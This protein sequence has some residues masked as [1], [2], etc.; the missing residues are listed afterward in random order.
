MSKSLNV[1]YI[2]PQP[3]PI[4]GATSKRRR[5]M[6]DYMNAHGIKSHYLI[7][8]FKQRDKRLNGIQGQYG[9]CEYW[10]ITP[11]AE[12]RMFLKF[13]KKGK[14]ILKKWYVKGK[15]NIVV[16]DTL[17]CWYDYPFYSKARRL[18]YKIVFDQVETS[19]L[20][21]EEVGVLRKWNLL[22]SEW[23]SNKAFSLNPAFVISYALM[24]E[25]A[26]KYPN[27]KLC[28]LPNSTPVLNEEPKRSLSVP[29]T[30][31]YAGTYAPKDGVKYLIDGVVEAYEKGC[32]CK[33]LLFG[34]GNACDM[35]IL[36]RVQDKD[37]IE[38]HGFV[39]EEELHKAMISADVLCMTRCNSRFA[40]YGFP[41][42][43]S[44]YLATGNILLATDVGDVCKYVVNGQS[45]YIVEPENSHVIAETIKHII[46]HED[47]AIGIAKG[48]FSVMQKY[49]SI[50]NVGQIFE[51]FL[52]IL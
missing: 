44:E 33:L 4:G 28:L 29:L 18:G 40:N 50:E 42:K 21:G 37:Y 11:L 3:F 45:S 27:R 36:E 6:V 30:L 1:V 35:K 14:S 16:F 5:Y 15:Q 39:S 34:K 31:L 38:Y 19:Y 51:N 23:L 49:F 41:F 2:G 43:L 32:S 24:K 10:D 20:Q 26:E 9:L 25:N 52:R 12:K 22:L 8:D 17:L 46:E 13:W 7:C 47:E 48:G